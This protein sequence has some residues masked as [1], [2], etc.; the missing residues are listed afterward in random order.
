RRFARLPLCRCLNTSASG[1]VHQTRFT[2]Y[3][4][5]LT[6]GAATSYLA[7]RL[8][9]DAHRVALDANPAGE[10]TLRPET[11]SSTKDSSE[12]NELSQPETPRDSIKSPEPIQ[13]TKDGDRGEEP[14]KSMEAVGLTAPLQAK[15]TGITHMSGEWHMALA[16]NNSKR[17]PPASFNQRKGQRALTASRSSMGC[18]IASRNTL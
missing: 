17:H 2:R 18:K 9:S 1:A 16:E 11:P 15:S 6:V 14:S 8:N 3:G 4:L 12:R 7:W 10:Q 13:D 5:A